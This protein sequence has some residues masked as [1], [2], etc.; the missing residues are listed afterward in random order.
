M[1]NASRHE[2]AW[3]T[4]LKKLGF[5]HTRTSGSHYILKHP[6]GRITI[7]AFHN[8]PIAKGTLKAILEQTKLTIKDLA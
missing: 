2:V 6:D 4:K 3:E 8:Q 5:I 1:R 7:I